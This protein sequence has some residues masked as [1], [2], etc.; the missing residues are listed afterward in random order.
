MKSEVRLNVYDLSDGWARR[1]SPMLL[2]RQIDGL[3]HTGIVVYGKEYFYGG[4][5]QYEL[6]E[7]VHEMIGVPE[8][9]QILGH[10]ELPKE[11]FHDFLFGIREKYA[12][13]NYNLFTQNCNHFSN[14]ITEFLIGKGIPEHIVNLPDICQ[15]TFVGGLVKSFMEK[16]QLMGTR[17]ENLDVD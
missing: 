4:G 9:T 15:E 16:M 13:C 11:L 2:G 7:K 5:V 12:D 1:V 17:I 10:T 6:S 14:E 3:W 8:E